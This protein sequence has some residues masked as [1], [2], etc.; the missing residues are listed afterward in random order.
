MEVC[1]QVRFRMWMKAL[2]SAEDD[3]AFGMFLALSGVPMDKA[4]ADI[5]NVR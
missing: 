2:D 4:W 5:R 1:S 3:D